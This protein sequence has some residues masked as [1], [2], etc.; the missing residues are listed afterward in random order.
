[1]KIVGSLG[2]VVFLLFI[3]ACGADQRTIENYEQAREVFWSQLYPDG[4]E[5]IYC[6]DKFTSASRWG[7]NIEHVFPMSWV[8]RALG[9]GRRKECR[10]GS[11]R[12]INDA[13]SSYRFAEL[14]GERRMFGAC[15]FE[16]DRRRRSVEPRLASRGEIARAMFYM[17]QEYGLIIFRSQGEMLQSWHRQDPPDSVERRR[18][19]HIEM[20]QGNRNPFIDRPELVDELQF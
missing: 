13:R 3:T 18:N 16:T 8:T 20:I 12:F 17:Q 4:G 15:D 5:T 2:R 19:D 9:C 14:A 10:E 11:S 6:G 7:L 1:M